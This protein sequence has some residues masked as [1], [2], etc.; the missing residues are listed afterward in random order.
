[1]I[2]HNT[3]ILVIGLVL[4]IAASCG[5]CFQSGPCF[6]HC[7]YIGSVIAHI[8]PQPVDSLHAAL[9]GM[10][11]LDGPWAT[12]IMDDGRNCR[13]YNNRL[14]RSAALVS[15]TECFGPTQNSETGWGYSVDVNAGK[16]NR[17]NVRKEVD[18]LVERIRKVIKANVGNAKVT[19]ETHILYFW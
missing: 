4:I 5:G 7:N 19:S 17:D 13:F 6:F 12:K 15:V 10:G 18:E 11:G 1:M 3:S 2:R 8:P 16:E 9:E 14:L